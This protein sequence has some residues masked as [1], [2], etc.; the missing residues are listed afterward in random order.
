MNPT[1]SSALLPSAAKAE[2]RG[3]P[4]GGQMMLVEC[5]PS[6]RPLPAVAVGG[7]PG[8]SAAAGPADG[9]G[10]GREVVWVALFQGPSHTSNPPP[11]KNAIPPVPLSKEG[12]PERPGAAPGPPRKA[13]RDRVG[14][15]RTTTRPRR[16]RCGVAPDGLPAPS[17]GA[18]PVNAA[19][20]LSTFLSNKCSIL[21]TK[22]DR[23][24]G[25]CE[26][27]GVFAVH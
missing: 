17:T 1:L 16:P 2:G 4:T 13:R 11:T 10:S 25:F 7:A 12:R 15:C 27:S 24:K 3:P 8:P 21:G 19:Q 5:G 6:G 18:P 9:P 20:N 22:T 26:F 23:K 14:T